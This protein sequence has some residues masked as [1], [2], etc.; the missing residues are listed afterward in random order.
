MRRIAK[1]ATVGG[2]LVLLMAVLWVAP[3]LRSRRGTPAAPV[4]N[5]PVGTVGRDAAGEADE[6]PAMLHD[7]ETVTGTLDPHELIGQRVDFS[8]KVA[9]INSYTSFWVG[10][11]DNRMLV[12]LARDNSRSD[13]QRDR[14]APSLNDIKPAAQGQMVRITGTIEGIPNAEARYSWGL[15]DSQRSELKDQKVYIR[16][17]HLMPEG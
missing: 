17:D 8:V 4:G 16:A 5:P 10:T 14:G 11:K 9:D 7:L 15:S 6:S 2:I 13:A 12:V 3:Y 1:W